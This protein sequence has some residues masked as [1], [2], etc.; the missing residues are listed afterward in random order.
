M[1]RSKLVIVI[2]CIF[3]VAM[4][5]AALTLNT[6]AVNYSF[7]EKDDID[8][9]SYAYSMAIIGDTQSL[10]YSDVQNAG[11]ADYE[12]RTE[13]IYDWLVAN[14][15]SKKIGMVLGLGDIVETWD[16][17]GKLED[18]E[19]EWELA[20]SQISK[21]N[22]KLPYTLVRGNH[23]TENGFNK[24][25]G[26]MEGYTGQFNG[27]NG[28][29]MTEGSYGTSY[30]K[31]EIANTKWLIVTLDWATTGA[32]LDWAAELIEANPDHSV[33]V[34]T[35]SYLFHDMTLDGEGDTQDTAKHNPDWD[36]SIDPTSPDNDPD[37]VYNPDGVWERLISKHSNIKLVLSGHVVNSNVVYSQ[38]VG[39]NGNT[40][41]QMLVNPQ[42]MDLDANNAGG[43]GMVCM[44]YF[45]EDGS[46]ADTSEWDGKTVN[47]EWYSTIKNQYYKDENQFEL[48]LDLYNGGTK[49]EKYGI[50]PAK[51]ANAE[52]Y[53]FVTFGYDDDTGEYFFHSAHK[54]WTT[55]ETAGAY[56]SL[57]RFS[58]KDVSAYILLRRDFNAAD[59][60]DTRYKNF[61]NLS[62]NLNIDLGGNTFTSSVYVFDANMKKPSTSTINVYGDEGSAFLVGGTVPLFWLG[63]NQSEADG[64]EFTYNFDG[65]RFGYAD[66]ATASNLLMATFSCSG[67]NAY[68]TTQNF[69]FN[70]C[71][72]DLSTKPSKAIKLI[73][74]DE[75]VG[76]GY[77]V[78][79]T[80]VT[81]NG[82]TI[83]ANGTD[84]LTL[85]TANATDSVL[86]GEGKNGQLTMQLP[87]N[88]SAPAYTCT[89][90]NGKTLTFELKEE[91]SMVDTYVLS[92]K[93]AEG[94]GTI[95][96]WLIGGQSNAAGF[97]T[98]T[99][100]AAL[101]DSRYSEGFSNV[102]Y[103][104]L[105]HNNVFTDAFVP[106]RYGLGKDSGSVGA[107]V[108]IASVVGN[109]ANMNAIIKVGIGSS[110]LYPDTAHEISKTYGTWTSPTYVSDHNISTDN[111][112]IGGLYATFLQTVANGI[113]LLEA[114]GYTPEI[115]GIWWMQGEAE[116]GTE[117]RSSCYEELLTDLICDMRADLGKIAGDD[118]STLPFV[119][120][121]IS[122]N[123]EKNSDGEY[124]YTQ[125]AYLDAVNAA[126]LKVV[127]SVENVFVVDTTGLAQA[128]GWHY[129]ANAQ[130][131]IGREFVNTVIYA[132][133][134]YSVTMNGANATLIGGGSKSEGEVV[135]VTIIANDGCV[136]NSVKYVVDGSDAVSVELDENGNYTFTMP[137]NSVVFEVEATDS[138]AVTTEYGVI[139]SMYA[140]GEKY[141]FIIFMDNKL[142][143]A[144]T[145]WSNAANAATLLIQGPTAAE[146]QAQMLLRADVS[147]NSISGISFAYIGGTLVL[148]LGNHTLTSGD[149]QIFNALGKT[150][151]G[152]IHDTKFVV[153]NGTLLTYGG[154]IVAF[155]N[156]ESADY[157][158]PKNFYFDFENVTF[159]LASGYETWHGMIVDCYSNGSVG[160]NGYIT[161]NNCMVDLASVEPT[162][163]LNIFD[164]NDTDNENNIHVIVKGGSFDLSD[165]FDEYVSIYAA[166]SENS[167]GKDSVVFAKD[168]SDN[169]TVFTSDVSLGF[170]TFESD[171]G[172]SMELSL[173]SGSSYTYEFSEIDDSRITNYGIISAEYNSENT[174]PFILFTDNECVKG[175]KTYYEFLTYAKATPITK[176]SVLYL[177]RDYKVDTTSGD[178]KS[179]N[180]DR[181][182]N[183]L[184]AHLTIDLNDK[185]L[186]KG[187]L[188]V[189]QIMGNGKDLSITVKNGTLHTS[190]GTMIPFN[191]TSSSSYKET[192]NY[193]FENVN[194]KTDAGLTRPFVDAYTGGT[195]AG[196]TVNM[197]FT[198]CVFDITGLGT[199]S[200]STYL[201]DLDEVDTNKIDFNVTINGGKMIAKALT[202]IGFAT[203]NAEREAGIG[204]PDVITFGT[205]EGKEFYL[206]LP[207]GVSTISKNVNT[208][209]GLLYFVEYSD[210]GEKS[211]SYLRS[212]NTKYGTI[213][214][215]NIS[216]LDYPFVLFQDGAF[217]GAYS[218]W[219]DFLAA[220]ANIDW[221]KESTL[222]LRRDYNTTECGKNSSALHTVGKLLIDLDGNKFTRGSYHIFQAIR[223]NDDNDRTDITLINGTL[224]V[225][226]NWSTIIAFNTNSGTVENDFGFDFTFNNVTLTSTESYQG[227]MVTEAYS[228]GN[229]G[230]KNTIV[231]NDC[232]FVIVSSGV[233]KLFQL[234]ESNGSNKFDIS[235]EINGG[236][237]IDSNSEAVKIATLSAERNGVVPDTV[238]FGK[239][240]GSYT[241]FEYYAA[242]T[243]VSFDFVSTSDRSISLKKI[244]SEGNDVYILGE[245]V[246]TK[247][248]YI[249]FA[250]ADTGEYPFAVFV[251]GKFGAAFDCWADNTGKENVLGYANGKVAT[252]LLRRDYTAESGSGNDAFNNFSHIANITLDLGG[253]T[254]IGS[255]RAVFQ[256]QAKNTGSAG[257]IDTYVY[258]MNGK[259]IVNKVAVIQ[260]NHANFAAYDRAEN[261]Y[262]T[263]TDVEFGFTDGATADG[264]VIS[265]IEYDSTGNIGCIP[266]VVFN[267]CVF[268][269]KS[270]TPIFNLND[271]KDLVNGTVEVIG[272]KIVSDAFL[273]S[274][275]ILGSENDKVRF[276]REDNSNYTSLMLPSGAEISSAEYYG[277]VFVEIDDD[278]VYTTYR[279]RPSEVSD[280]EFVPK[281]SLTLDRNLIL[282][283]YIPSVS[284]LDSFT[285]DGKADSE[286]EVKTVNLDGVDYYLVSIPLS[287]NEAA[288]MITLKAKIAIGEKSATATFTFGIIKYAEKILED[289]SDIEKTLVRDV[290]SYIRAA[291]IYFA[292]DDA[293]T[294][295]KI[296]SILGENYDA[297][298]LPEIEGSTGAETLELDSATFS[299]DGTPAMRFYLANGADASKYTF[300]INGKQVAT[301]VSADGKYVDIDV[302]AYEL[303]ETVTYTIDGIEC[304]S[305]HINAYYDW[306]KTQ[307]NE[308]LVNLVARFWKYLQSARAYRESVVE[309]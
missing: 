35:H 147:T 7:F 256:A 99:L 4:I 66:G 108:G 191:N 51:Y 211:L 298:N 253:N 134:K 98:G 119:V 79:K 206:E 161:L 293:D 225:E 245:D 157:T 267:N 262:F 1:K 286:Y 222:V 28:A 295:S 248:G 261:L 173:I 14:K 302:Y 25:I 266:S 93:K 39:D 296:D 271:S 136:I 182:L 194:F 115:K 50:I 178:V 193:V 43:C 171:E 175:F 231:F 130:Y 289:G 258:V 276:G 140:D 168:A 125:P 192:V 156:V 155:N 224:C 59:A 226:K 278:G 189:L 53:P 82:G 139:P 77:Y 212:L 275:L 216:A 42:S 186:T 26:G 16:E 38:V 153:K 162:A 45:K 172:A 152:Y 62:V 250:Y 265:T 71:T 306:S 229:F 197:T 9:S 204:S 154:P 92:E 34:T 221:T 240:N 47:V 81:I 84:D 121:E 290:L 11:V 70:N 205:Y 124:I 88:A 101:T 167:Y 239:Y 118:L 131:H 285:L 29:F 106:V 37:L 89:A 83:K 41:T 259:F 273:E 209:D 104:G 252:V 255:S 307:N 294:V 22:G 40:V 230:S 268:N 17:A 251:G 23:D 232:I 184:G 33:I 281:M 200:S 146:K 52:E 57:S 246:Y 78:Q 279:L 91:G 236:K 150:T 109:S 181:N 249:P 213:S 133:G 199:A 2:S 135:T 235:I 305:F 100:D 64:A 179:S 21:L 32:E 15:E 132:E 72:F 190:N 86:F 264:L 165:S 75:T 114:E 69:N 129:T 105:G 68:S 102:V 36:D 300:F 63:T 196:T 163:A 241:V 292:T 8:S 94:K 287:A 263:F 274:D 127:S 138:N 65:I 58:A 234:D 54:N 141:P 95:D 87:A 195:D 107:E 112:K 183:C 260:F 215:S 48:D 257:V 30:R 122:R 166:N 18:F 227:R 10:I 151:N 280:V 143:G 76:S 123:Q 214:T 270:G 218:K 220:A 46:L 49:T 217:I 110:Y 176:A 188:H 301:E 116:T 208:T 254:Y 169:Y 187:N 174:Y 237:I 80:N 31:F 269:T 97:G 160:C 272:G 74:L 13:K 158:S 244:A 149:A 277:F 12:P 55:A 56:L 282:N 283:V 210:D 299:L 148:D 44:L 170:R 120:G 288:R 27:E 144:Y 185:V 117:L 177:R 3:L 61:G 242:A 228:N 67:S 19:A 73:Q 297:N 284:Y 103:Y 233:L 207:S 309:N 24:Y 6:G 126:Q 159:G 142:V 247:Y 198:N 113:A 96:V 202:K 201:F 111:N 219:Y 291:Y 238:K 145:S 243:A 85:Y 303:C 128:D 137:N 223:M 308:N 5:S 60:G 164:L 304:G 90:N 180:N 203:H 20:V